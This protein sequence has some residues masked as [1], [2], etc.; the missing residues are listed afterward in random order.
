VYPGH[1]DKDKAMEGRGY[2]VS[3]CF[4]TVAEII[5]S[6]CLV[7]RNRNS[8]GNVA[9]VTTGAGCCCSFI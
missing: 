3:S 5:I 2:S 6:D 1:R 7:K 9:V 8:L 4:V